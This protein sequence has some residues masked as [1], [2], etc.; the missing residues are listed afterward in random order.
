VSVS[1]QDTPRPRAVVAIEAAACVVFLM[2][3]AVL[4]ARVWDGSRGLTAWLVLAPAALLGYFVADVATGLVHWFC[5][6][7]F[8]EDSPVVGRLLIFPFR[9][10]HR[11]PRAMTRHGVLELTGNSCLATSPVLAAAL[12]VPLGLFLDAALFV[13][14]QAVVATNLFH[15]WAHDERPPRLAAWLQARGLV[16]APVVHDV[17]HSHG[18]R[19]AYCVTN[20]WANRW[21]DGLGVFERLESGLGALGVPATRVK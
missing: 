11:D 4:A 15:G 1:S 3:I 17:H 18:G 20:G 2:L 19:G 9:D 14:A 16:L 21:L 5:D 8:E 7:F 6:R 10:H 12:A 13:F